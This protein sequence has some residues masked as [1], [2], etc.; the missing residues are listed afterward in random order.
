MSKLSNAKRIVA[1]LAQ[2]VPQPQ[3]EPIPER[4]AIADDPIERVNRHLIEDIIGELLQAI[5]EDPDRPGLA[6]TPRR[7]A[8]FWKEFLDYDPGE[9]GTSFEETISAGAPVIVSGMRV[10]SLCEHH[11]M[12]FWADVTVAYIPNKR[13]LGLSKLARIA[14]MHAHKLQL[15]ERLCHQIMDTVRALASTADVAVIASGMHSCM[16]ARGIRTPGLMTSMA[17]SGRYRLESD[18]LAFVHAQHV[19]K[20]GGDHG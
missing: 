12:P 3:P 10:H 16:V 13:V 1:T 7:V 8:A 11:L 17:T 5:G 6:D 2:A 9:I 18:L 20:M 4:I 14:H 19:R 15:Q